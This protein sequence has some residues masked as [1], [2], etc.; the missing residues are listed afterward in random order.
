MTDAI[1][2]RAAIVAA[3]RAHRER[4]QQDKEFAKEVAQPR[5]AKRGESKH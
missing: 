5:Q 3:T 4:S 1:R 2:P